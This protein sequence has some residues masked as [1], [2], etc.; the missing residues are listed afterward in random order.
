MSHTQSFAVE[1]TPIGLGL[2][3]E[4]P[5]A[6]GASVSEQPWKASRLL[7]VDDSRMLLSL[8]KAVFESLGFEVSATSSP[9]E[10]LEQLSDHAADV[11]ILDYDMPG[12][13]GGMLAS[14]MKDRYPTLPVI[15]YSGN[16]SI[17]PSARHWVDAVCAKASPRE[18]LLATI[19]RLSHQSWRDPGQQSR[20]S[21]APSSNH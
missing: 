14:L 16:N 19:D 21:L 20:Q 3:A 4:P 17:P 5:T 13:D 18:E 6:G 8:Y 1:S 11:A 15:L 9:E 2:P 12:M 10:A 7:W